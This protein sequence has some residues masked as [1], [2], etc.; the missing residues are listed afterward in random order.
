MVMERL[1]R[2]LFFGSLALFLAA[3]WLSEALPEPR[4]VRQE[5]LSDPV[6]RLR[7]APA[8]KTEVG[9]VRYSVQP[10]FAY[11]LYGLLVSRHDTSVWW[12]Y[13]HKEW[14]DNLNVVDLCVVWGDNIRHDAYRPISFSN[15]QWTC[16]YETRSSEA[17][18]AFSTQAISNNHMITDNPRIAEML[19]SARVGDQIHVRGYLADYT[20]MKEGYSALQRVTSTVRNDAGNGACEVVYVEDFEILK[21]GGG[22]WR[23]LKWIAAGLLGVSIIAWFL[24]PARLYR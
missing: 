19:R 16:W 17:M 1:V 8:F 3:L 7:E 10:R 2:M 6:Q 18:Q 13:I 20:V 12:D 4:A 24:L 23:K 15:D 21:A 14:N 22:L 9:G 11:E 5:L